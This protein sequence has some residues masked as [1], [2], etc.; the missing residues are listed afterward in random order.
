MC[1]V[2]GKAL[3]LQ[4]E[5]VL[6]VFAGLPEGDTLRLPVK[7]NRDNEIRSEVPASPLF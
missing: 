5:E 6:S 1:R 3:P 4:E 7:E 2:S